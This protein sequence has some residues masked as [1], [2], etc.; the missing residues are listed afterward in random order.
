MQSV[1]D[2]GVE[3]RSRDF[4]LG[5]EG[6]CYRDL[7]RAERL[8]RLLGAF[9]AGLRSADE[10]LFQ[11][12]ADYRKS[13]GADLDDVA[14]SELLVALAPHLG[15]FVASLFGVE[16]ERRAVMERTRHDYAALFTYKRAVVDKAG[17][18]FKTQNPGDWDLD[19]LDSDMELLKRTA[20][21]ECAE[22]RDDECA[23]SV[24][25]ARLANLAGHYQKLA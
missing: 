10:E 5:I 21:P 19:K 13:Q 16:D 2:S 7:F 6:F 23:T 24:V 25:G 8:E 15:A 14:I 11:S 17:A 18:K 22:D 9:D 20:A 12:Y 4:P 1:P 3:E